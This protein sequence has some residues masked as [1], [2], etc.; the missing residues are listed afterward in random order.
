MGIQDHPRAADRLRAHHEH[1]E[2]SAAAV[3]TM[4][5]RVVVLPLGAARTV[6]D[7][8]VSVDGHTHSSYLCD[9]PHCAPLTS[10]RCLV[11]PA[12]RHC[13]K[14]YFLMG[15]LIFFCANL[16]LAVAG[17]PSLDHLVCSVRGARHSHS[18]TTSCCQN[19]RCCW[20]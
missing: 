20:W 16:S 8:I 15:W 4:R 6:S 18:H 3:L 13:R 19:H 9:T 11:G 17:T 5:G 1:E 14:P 2:A 12:A 10:S 7:C